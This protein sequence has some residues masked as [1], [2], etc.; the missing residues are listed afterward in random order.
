[1]HFEWDPAKA[2]SNLEKHQVSFDESATVFDDPLA[3]TFPDPDHSGGERR[4]VTVD[5]SI[6]AQLLVV[7]HTERRGVL[8]LISARRATP[9][10]RRRHETG[11][12][13]RSG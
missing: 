5:F 6:S 8:R 3:I 2:E 13:S 12:P 7:G 4:Y 11:K 10:E 1:M 9:S